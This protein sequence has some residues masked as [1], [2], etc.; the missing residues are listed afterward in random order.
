[1]SER[2]RL[3]R[4]LH[5]RHRVGH[6]H[7]A[8]IAFGGFVDRG[9]GTVRKLQPAKTT[10]SLL[11]SRF[12]PAATCRSAAIHGPAQRLWATALGQFADRNCPARQFALPAQSRTG[13]PD[14][15][16]TRPA[17]KAGRGAR[18]GVR[19]GGRLSPTW[20][21]PRSARRYRNRH[22]S[23]AARDIEEVALHVDKHQCRRTHL[24]MDAA[25]RWRHARLLAGCRPV[26]ELNR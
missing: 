17:G 12:R 22:R 1:M 20:Q 10:V 19:V 25:I 3:P 26:I 4:S 21:L 9:P 5:T 14:R 18:S 23:I 11:L 15:R 13:E 16:S 24:R 6:Q 2:P 8:E 7:D